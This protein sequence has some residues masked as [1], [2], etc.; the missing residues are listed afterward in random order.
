MKPQFEVEVVHSTAV[1]S[2][3][4]WQFSKNFQETSP[5]G[6]GP[7]LPRL[8]LVL[9]L[10][11][12][13]KSLLTIQGKQHKSGL[14]K[15]LYDAPELVVGLQQ[16]ME[17]MHRRTLRSLSLACA[18]SLLERRGD[19]TLLPRFA[20]CRKTL[21]R[22]LNPTHEDVRMMLSASRRLG[23]WLSAHDLTFICTQLHVRF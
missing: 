9:P 11:F 18:S 19:S 6:Q 5:D 14:L 10:V 15:V 16:R 20:S 7:D 23:T 12:H 21:P 13:Q 3:A 17:A 4:L 1:G 22:D 2:V 8:M